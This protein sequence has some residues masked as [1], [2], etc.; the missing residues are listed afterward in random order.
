MSNIAIKRLF[1][2]LLVFILL[3]CSACEKNSNTSLKDSLNSEI[4]EDDTWNNN[5]SYNSNSKEDESTRL[6]EYAI[7]YDLGEL[8]D[9]SYISFTI[10]S[11]AVL[12]NSEFVLDEPSCYG[13]I[14]LGWKMVGSNEYCQ[15]GVYGW[16]SDIFLIA[17]WEKDGK[18]GRWWTPMY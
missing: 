3:G 7:L 5:E 13:Y 11:K 8:K 6:K 14:F 15:N 1:C 12:E 18:S 10:K 16:Q 9:D 17:D 4:A 2:I